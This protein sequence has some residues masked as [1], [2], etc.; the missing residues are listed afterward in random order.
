[1]A[2]QQSAAR[3]EAASHASE[4]IGYLIEVV[5]SEKEQLRSVTSGQ[6][7]AFSA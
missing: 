1:L 6:R 5:R 2:R 4:V 3:L 7:G